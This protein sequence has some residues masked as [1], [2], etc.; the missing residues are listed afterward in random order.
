ML[1]GAAEV[2]AVMAVVDSARVVGDVGE[3]DDDVV[4][5]AL[6]E[7]EQA[8]TKAGKASHTHRALARVMITDSTCS[9]TNSLVI[10]TGAAPFVALEEVAGVDHSRG[11]P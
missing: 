10:E 4:A 1:S 9:A 6:G 8:V 5:R 7:L 11:R 2:S 3:V